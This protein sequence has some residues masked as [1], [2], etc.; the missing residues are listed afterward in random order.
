MI[1]HVRESRSN[2]L[3]SR[4]AQMHLS[5]SGIS[6]LKV[7]AVFLLALLVLI[8]FY[9]EVLFH[10]ND[11]LLSPHGY[12]IKNYYTYLFHAKYDSDFWNFGGMNYP[13]YEHMVYT[14]GHPLLSLVI[15][16]FGLA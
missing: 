4:S 7:T 6:K 11:Y 14:D 8:Y 9:Y 16:A 12:G 2:S 5:E 3:N 15:R 13:Y 10:P 1:I